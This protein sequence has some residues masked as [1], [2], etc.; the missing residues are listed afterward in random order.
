RTQKE[1]EK[2][3]SEEAIYHE[4]K[5][6]KNVEK[7]NVFFNQIGIDN[8]IETDMKFTIYT[9]KGEELIGRIFKYSKENH[10]ELVNLSLSMPSLNDVFLSLTGKE[11]RDGGKRGEQ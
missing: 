3:D 10:F 5:Y 4:L 1:C 9:S 2:K 7:I 8:V 11:L 6:M